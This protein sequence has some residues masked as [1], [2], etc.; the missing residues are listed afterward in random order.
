MPKTKQCFTTQEVAIVQ[1]MSAEGHCRRSIAAAIG[2]RVKT[3][4]WHRRDR[5]FGTLPN[6][7]GQNTYRKERRIPDSEKSGVL[8]G[9]KSSDWQTTRDR[10]KASWDS[11]ELARR[12]Y[13]VMPF[14][15]RPFNLGWLHKDKK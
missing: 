11:E 12:S 3:F 9:L 13:S 7:Q 10:I 14:G 6:R 8:F 15:E 4:E 5:K 1:K 2:I